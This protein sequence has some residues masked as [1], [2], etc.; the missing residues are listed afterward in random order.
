MN[1]FHERLS[2]WMSKEGINASHLSESLKREDGSTPASKAIYNY[3]TGHNSPSIE[4]LELLDYHFPNLN[5]NWIVTG[6]GAMRYSES[7]DY[8]ELIKVDHS[9][10]NNKLATV[11]QIL[12]DLLKRVGKLENQ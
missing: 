8:N 4:F 9:A 10:L 2:W 12:K 6:K 7:L 11:D 1:T 3:M 5:I